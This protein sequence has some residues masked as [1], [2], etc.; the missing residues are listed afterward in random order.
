MT[1]VAVVT[2]ASRGIG[3]SISK[4][5]LELGYTVYGICRNPE[6]CNF[7]EENFHLIKGDLKDPKTIPIF[8]EQIPNKDKIH[9]LVN[10]A[11]LSY[12]APIE[13]LS[14]DKISEMTQVLLNA[15]MILSSSLTRILKQNEGRI[16]FIGSVSGFQIS[17]WGNVYGSLKAGLHQFA[18]L[19]YDELR[20]YSVK[21]HLVIPDIT[22][23]DFYHDLNIEPDSDPRSYLIPDQI[24][25]VV[26]Q[27]LLDQSGL[28]VPE[29]VVRPEVFKLKRK[30]FQK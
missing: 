9:I 22:K 25:N 30:K 7:Y 18:R 3:L 1:Q 14:S 27:I 24:A 21:V 12:F 16:F 2:G 13:E 20:K 15:P 10:N 23:T 17:P 29:I 28:V 4:V 8:L 5:L 19:L 11:G 6:T 26:K